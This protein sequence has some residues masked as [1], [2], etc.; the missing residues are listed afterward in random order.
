MV[1]TLVGYLLLLA[2]LKPFRALE[3]GVFPRSLQNALGSH[4]KLKKIIFLDSLL[5]SWTKLPRQ[6]LMQF[7]NMPNDLQ[8]L[9]LKDG[10]STL[11]NCS[12]MTKVGQ[13]FALVVGAVTRDGKQAFHKSGCR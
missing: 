5:Q 13:V 6:K 1:I 8:L 12:A 11:T 9:F 7:T 10:I 2:Q 3:N 4:L